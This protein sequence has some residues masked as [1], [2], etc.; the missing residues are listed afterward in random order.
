MLPIGRPRRIIEQTGVQKCILAIQRSVGITEVLFR[1]FYLSAIENLAEVVQFCPASESHHHA[2]PG[3]LFVHILESC[4]NSLELRRGI[5]LPAGAPPEEVSTKKNLYS[6]AVFAACLLHDV[7][8]PLTDQEIT[9]HTRTGRYLCAW[10]P[11]SQNIT[12]VRRAVYMRIRFRTDRVYAHH[13]HSSLIYLQRILPGEGIRW[14]LSD[15]GVYSEFLQAFSSEPGGPIWRLMSRGDQISVSKALGAQRLPNF[16]TGDRPLWMKIRT[17]LR[18]LIENGELSLNRRGTAGWV[19]QAG[20]WL[21]SKRAVDAV[22]EQLSREG[23]TGVPGDNNRIYDVMAESGMLVLNPQGKAIWRCRVSIGDWAPDDPLSVILL[24]HDAIWNDPESVPVFEGR[25]EIVQN[26]EPGGESG[27]AHAPSVGDRD[28]GATATGSGNCVEQVVEQVLSDIPTSRKPPAS[29]AVQ[30][31][32]GRVQE[33]SS[34]DSEPVRGAEGERF[35]KWIERGVN[36]GDLTI[37]TQE[38]IVHF[39]EQGL[40]L[41]SPAAFRKYGRGYSVDWELVQQDF[42]SLKIN[43]KNPGK[44]DQNWWEVRVEKGGKLSMLKGWLVPYRHFALNVA[45][46]FNEVLTLIMP[47]GP[48]D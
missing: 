32:N 36:Q 9:L 13:Q 19:D 31:G 41:V 26:N 37:N 47:E 18:H 24:P 20:V 46:E 16:G 4:A 11:V 12:S 25:I 42:Q 30:A 10:D 48:G 7:A 38:S 6:Y 45:P 40:L 21:V 34:R 35:R 39:L 43:R 2:W 23:H 28:F 8:K 27:S 5:G 1:R 29:P 17:S 3:G 14:I 15:K 44:Q 22:R 33:D